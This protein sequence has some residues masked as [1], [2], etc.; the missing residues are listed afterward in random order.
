M[1][2]TTDWTFVV[3][4]SCVLYVDGILGTPELYRIND[5]G[6]TIIKDI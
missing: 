5:N 4:S 3:N 2:A 1:N 6:S